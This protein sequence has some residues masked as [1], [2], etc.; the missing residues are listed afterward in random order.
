MAEVVPSS[1]RTPAVWEASPSS[2]RVHD[3]L[4][5]NVVLTPPPPSPSPS[6]RRRG[7]PAAQPTLPVVMAS[8]LPPKHKRGRPTKAK[9]PTGQP[10]KKPRGRPRKEHVNIL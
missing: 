5:P 6:R 4:S 1:S 3:E 2:A 9:S 7:P 10:A 8:S